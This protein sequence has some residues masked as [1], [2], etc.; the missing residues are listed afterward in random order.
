VDIVV[1]SRRRGP[2][3]ARRPQPVSQPAA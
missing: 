2:L 3:M 1:M